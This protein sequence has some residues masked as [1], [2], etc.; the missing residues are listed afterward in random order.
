MIG[1][2]DLEEISDRELLFEF[3]PHLYRNE[4]VLH[5][6]ENRDAHLRVLPKE[7]A[8]ILSIIVVLNQEAG[9]RTTKHV[10]GLFP[11]GRKRRDQNDAPDL[12][13]SGKIK[14]NSR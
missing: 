9:Q 8:K 1:S 2:F 4:I 10:G 7:G 5:A 6:V 14:R 3:A 13:M 11:Q 12:V